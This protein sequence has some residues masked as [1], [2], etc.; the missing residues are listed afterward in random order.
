MNLL[1]CFLAECIMLV[2]IRT[3]FLFPGQPGYYFLYWMMLYNVWFAFFNLIPVPPL[4]GSKI[5][6]MLLPGKWAWHYHNISYRYS[7][8]LLMVLVFSGAV[9]KII[10]PLSVIYTGTVMKI[11]DTVLGFF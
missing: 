7:F 8:I 6:E 9:G 3:G 5:A 1:I 4:D 2:M 10:G 11:I